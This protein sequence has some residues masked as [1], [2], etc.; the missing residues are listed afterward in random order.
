MALHTDCSRIKTIGALW[1]QAGHFAMV[2][3]VAIHRQKLT[4]I[5]RNVRF[6]SLQPSAVILTV[7]ASW[8]IAEQLAL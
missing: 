5:Q 2:A 3:A 1:L 6:Q 8:L 7:A 4:R